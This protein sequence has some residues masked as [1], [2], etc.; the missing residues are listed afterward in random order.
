M[1]HRLAVGVAAAALLSLV[2]GG[3]AEAYEPPQRS[4]AQPVPDREQ[5][6]ARATRLGRSLVA[7][8]ASLGLGTEDGFRE[9]DRWV[10]GR[11]HVHVRYHQTYRGVEVY[12]GVVVGHVD[13]DGNVLPPD[14]TVQRGID[15]EPAELLDETA[16]R[17]L[18]SGYLSPHPLFG[19][20]HVRPIVFPTRYR[21]GIGLRRDVDGRFVAD[22]VCGAWA[23]NRE[24]YR[25]AFLAGASQVA[26]GRLVSTG[27]V[28]DGRTGEIL[29][30]WDARRYAETPSTG[31]GYGQYNGTVEL[32][33]LQRTDGDVLFTLADT[34]RPTAPWVNAAMYSEFQP[35]LG[36]VGNKT[37]LHDL[38]S[39][40]LQAKEFTDADD[41]WGNGEAFVWNRDYP[42]RC[43]EPVGQ[44]AAVD[45]H[46][47]VQVA[48]DYLQHV[49]G[50]SGP[51][52]QGSSLVSLVHRA[53]PFLGQALGENAWMPFDHVLTF[54]S[55]GPSGPLA[56]L[57]LV[58][59]EVAHALMAYTAN[60][61]ALG[62]GY[63]DAA[64][65]E[66]NSDIHATMVKYY[67]WGAGGAGGV[68]PDTTTDAPGGR[69]TREYLW[70]FG[71]QLSGDG[72][73]PLRYL[74]KP[75][76][77]GFGYDAWFDGVGIDRPDWSSGPAV[78]AFF[79]LGQ[80]ASGD[81]T[82]ETYSEYLP[83]G[84][85]GI[86]NDRAI[87]IWYHAMTTKVTDAKTDYYLFR[88]AM[89]AAAAELFPGTGGADSEEVAA[90][91]NAFAAVNVGAPAEGREPV[92]VVFGRHTSLLDNEK[93]ILWPAETAAP[94]PAPTV[95][96]AEDT[97]VTWSLGGLS[98]IY[99][100]GGR[101]EDGN[102]I[103]PIVFGSARFPVTA[104]SN[105]DPKQFATTLVFALPLDL[106]ADFETD[107]CDLAAL[108]H[109][110]GGIFQRYPS[111]DIFGLGM[112]GPM[113]EE[114]SMIAF[115]EAF[116]NAFNR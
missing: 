46:Y 63:E 38:M 116:E 74:Y 39:F 29:K 3:P 7:T 52:G 89:I 18:V 87:R 42:D 17:S 114:T 82:A 105:E 35:F 86:G 64:L 65:N 106:D 84:M 15:L 73:T 2:P 53:D 75:S 62:N 4:G 66:A 34:T 72:V 30:R 90:V 36:G 26:E 45:V 8:K 115:I 20:I 97:S 70:S 96:N 67:R 33:T 24:V 92:R 91:K 1:V 94:L 54:G 44:T 76:K 77:N 51:D 21:D 57:D 32:A 14:A 109:D 56:S 93:F 88:E 19:P 60:L 28:L 37:L 85:T 83:E 48:W 58:A 101:F 9:R 59:H 31:T 113:V 22:F 23:Q 80:G 13:A 50:R 104:T 81:P 49:L 11:G 55:G 98:Y 41:E 103:A 40:P 12:N 25:W 95:T 61:D 108:A 27:F 68:V 111:A 47:G 43:L 5:F 69:N 107:A 6:A 16:I 99:P 79:F 102:F 71:P 100:E 110:Y 78:R 10:D 112:A